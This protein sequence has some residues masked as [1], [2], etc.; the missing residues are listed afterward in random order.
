MGYTVSIYTAFSTSQNVIVA[1]ILTVVTVV[2]LTIYA[3]K[4]EKDFTISVCSVSL[5]ETP[6]VIIINYSLECVISRVCV[7]NWVFKIKGYF[8]KGFSGNCATFS[9]SASKLVF[10][11]PVCDKSAVWM[12]D[13]FV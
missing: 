2:G 8:R 3:W 7:F 10:F 1:L 4:T 11:E 13:E 9:R 5:T 6:C 12:L